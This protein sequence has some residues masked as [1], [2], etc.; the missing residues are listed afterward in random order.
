MITRKKK[1]I[2]KIDELQQLVHINIT[3]IRELKEQN[4]ILSDKVQV[5]ELQVI[6]DT[7]LAEQSKQCGKT[8]VGTIY[9]NMSFYDTPTRHTINI[10]DGTKNI[11][12]Y[13]GDLSV[14]DHK[15]NYEKDNPCGCGNATPKNEI[16]SAIYAYM[17]NKS[18]NNYFAVQP[19]T[20]VAYI[21][22]DMTTTVANSVADILSSTKGTSG[23]GTP[24]D[25]L[26]DS[27]NKT[28]TKKSK[29]DKK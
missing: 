16:V 17:Y 7:L 9:K 22:N 10:Y 11:Y 19:T 29:K 24:D 25:G 21:T 8:F 18:K 13:T 3:T 4:K 15:I 26:T 28:E 20:S 14:I 6:L 1:M 12:S 27:A 23:Y 5:L 2:T